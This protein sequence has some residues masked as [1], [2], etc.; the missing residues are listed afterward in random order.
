[1]SVQHVAHSLIVSCYIVNF[2]RCKWCWQNTSKA[3]AVCVVCWILPSRPKGEIVRV[4]VA[5]L[6]VTRYPHRG[7]HCFLGFS[8]KWVF[9]ALLCILRVGLLV[10]SPNKIPCICSMLLWL[11]VPSLGFSKRR[12]QLKGIRI[13]P[14]NWHTLCP[15]PLPLP[16]FF[17]GYH[18]WRKYQ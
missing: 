9:M 5:V 13:L 1:M 2:I 17:I 8:S 16:V 18:E 10:H 12:Y 6:E 7:T 14:H 3:F 11:S 15:K 4:C